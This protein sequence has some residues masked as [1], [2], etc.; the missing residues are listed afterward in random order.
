MVLV[1]AKEGVKAFA[2]SM[3]EKEVAQDLLAA[4]SVLY[5]KRAVEYAASAARADEA[6]IALATCADFVM[7]TAAADTC[8][9]RWVFP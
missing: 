3:E 5:M 4:C 6:V 8:D 2:A 7:V 1:R 9:L